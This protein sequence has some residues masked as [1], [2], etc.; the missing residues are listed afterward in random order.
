MQL[1]SAFSLP[2]HYWSKLTSWYASLSS[3]KQSI[4]QD[5]VI[6]GIAL[7]CLWWVTRGLSLDRLAGT[8]QAA[9]LWMFVPANVASFFLWWLGDT[10]IFSILFS[11]F[12]RK[13]GFRELLPATAAQYFLQAVNILA[14]DGALVVFLNRRKGVRWLAAVWTV[15][16]QAFIDALVLAAAATAAGVLMPQSPLRSVLPYTAGA[17][18]FLILVALWWAWGRPITRPEKWIYNRPSAHAFRSAG[19]REY[20]TLGGI[21]FA[22][23]AVQAFLYYISI[24]AFAPK[25]PL[26]AVIALAPALQAATNEPATPQ[27]LGPFQAI[28][29][30]AL[31]PYAPRDKVI[32]AAL[33]I[34]ILQLLCR[35]TLGFG[36][37]GT[38]ARRVLKIE[39][40]EKRSTGR[41]KGTEREQAS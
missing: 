34:S 38:F 25:V 10:L 24:A 40:S 16:Y 11:F 23:V 5:F 30:S 36:A 29:A 12:H 2:L 28:V 6:W 9:R 4:A 21:R 26:H 3:T 33:G 39:A 19:W 22:M 7:L 20:L 13:T 1:G 18:A 14:A 17:S 41:A 37:A 31:S 15:M 8:F 35:L 32:A 27:G